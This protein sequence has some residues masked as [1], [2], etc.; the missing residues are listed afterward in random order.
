MNTCALREHHVLHRF[1]SPRVEQNLKEAEYDVTSAWPAA[2]SSSA[3]LV[4]LHV[5]NLQ[6]KLSRLRVD[7][8]VFV[9]WV[10]R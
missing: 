4:A 10:G 1:F 3:V 6:A 2:A 8:W 9:R 5:A 7:E